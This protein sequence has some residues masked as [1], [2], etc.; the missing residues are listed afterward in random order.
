MKN[1]FESVEERLSFTGRS[2][3]VWGPIQWV[4]GTLSRYRKLSG[5][6]S[7]YCPSTWVLICHDA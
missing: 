3:R 7:D 5:R 4:F 2:D 6:E 1:N